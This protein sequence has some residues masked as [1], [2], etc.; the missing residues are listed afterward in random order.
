MRTRSQRSGFTLVEVLL[1][2]AITALL[3]TGAFWSLHQVVLTRNAVSNKATPYVMGPAILDVMAA[4][5]ANAAF[6]DIKDNN[7]FYAT[8]AEINGREA[9]A[10][11]LVTYRKAMAPEQYDRADDLRDSW[12]N[13]VAWVMR[14]GQPGTD[15]LELW[16]RE[17]WNVDDKP[18][19]DGDFV[20]LYDKVESLALQFVPRNSGGESKSAGPAGNVKD[21]DDV[22]KDGWNAVKEQ[23]LQRAVQITL[24]IWARDDAAEVEDKEQDGKARLYTFKRFVALPQVHMSAESQVQIASWDGKLTEPT[25]AARGGANAAAAAAGAAGGPGRGGAG[26]M[27]PGGPR[28]AAPGRGRGGRGR[29]NQQGMG[30]GANPFL[31]ALQGHGR[32]ANSAPGGSINLGALFGNH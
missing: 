3:F 19:N 12:V 7:A 4:D 16:R 27:A 17:D 20:L 25:N 31:Q 14:R 21:D 29:N 8:D 18:H 6:Y 13:E 9:D 1:A 26:P 2:L 32:P 10:L 28:G 23:G 30:N 5:I 11:S 22:L 24:T 15:Y